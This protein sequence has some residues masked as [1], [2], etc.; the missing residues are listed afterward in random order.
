MFRQLNHL[1]V[2]AD[3]RYARAEELNFLRDYLASVDTRIS[4]YEKIRTEGELMADKIQAKQKA[5]NP[6]CF[7]YAQRDR[8]EICRRDL[9]DAIRLSASAML[10][11]ELDL[12]RDNFLLWYRT[13]VKAFNYE[14][15][16]DSTYG[17][18]LPAMMKQL[19]TPE[20][21]RVMQPVLALSSSILSQ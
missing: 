6:H 1:T 16:A 21:Q 9:V 7:H 12:M 10:F 11:A 15:M 18:L 14:T 19:L 5:E 20:E 17:K 4:A 2:S 8:S 3:G 13:I